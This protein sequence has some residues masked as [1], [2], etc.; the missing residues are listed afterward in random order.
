[1]FSPRRSHRHHPT[2]R[3]VLIGALIALA[4]AIWA[5]TA[6]GSTTLNSA[7]PFAGL[8]NGVALWFLAVVPQG[9]G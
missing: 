5:G 3:R 4:F 1:M 9:T 6:H 8:E 2:S 7:K